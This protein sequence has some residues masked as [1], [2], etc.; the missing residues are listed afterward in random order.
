MWASK[1]AALGYQWLVG[2]GK[3]MCFCEGHWFGNSSLII[4]FFHIDFV[5]NE[6]HI[7]INEAWDGIYLKLS[8]GRGFDY[9]MMQQRNDL[10]QIVSD[11]R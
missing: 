11:I 10:L 6:S 1:A 5:F 3:S 9:K 2:D 7:T 4:Q 8:F